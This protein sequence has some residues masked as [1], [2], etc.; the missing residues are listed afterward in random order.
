MNFLIYSAELGMICLNRQDK[1]PFKKKIRWNFNRIL[2]NISNGNLHC[3][4]E[5]Y[6][7]EK[8]RFIGP[9]TGAH[10]R[11]KCTLSNGI[12]IELNPQ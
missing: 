5:S 12:E 6:A 1:N 10:Q 11:Q 9:N 4:Y 7:L 8:I 3:K 2:P